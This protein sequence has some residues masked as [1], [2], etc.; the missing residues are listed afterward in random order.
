MG[1]VVVAVSSGVS[2]GGCELFVSAD[3]GGDAVTVTFVEWFDDDGTSLFDEL[4]GG[5]E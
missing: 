1:A 2:N 4:D 3:V 5:G